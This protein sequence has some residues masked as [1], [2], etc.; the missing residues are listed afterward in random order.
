MFYNVEKAKD[1]INLDGTKFERKVLMESE[2][3]SLNLIA[4]KKDEIIGKIV[5][6]LYPFSKIKFY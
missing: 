3:G 5:M 6:R 4:I 2:N 1:I